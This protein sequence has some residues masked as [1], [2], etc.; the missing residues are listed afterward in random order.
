MR[1]GLFLTPRGLR[2]YVS[3][4]LRSGRH[5]ELTPGQSM[6]FAAMVLLAIVVSAVI[7][8]AVF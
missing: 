2:P 8:L 7:V 3:A 4:S 1:Y 5:Q 6:A